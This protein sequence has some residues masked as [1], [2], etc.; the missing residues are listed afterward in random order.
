MGTR[1]F[2]GSRGFLPHLVIRWKHGGDVPAHSR[3][4]FSCSGCETAQQ[5]ET[6]LGAD[7]REFGTTALATEPHFGVCMPEASAE[8]R[9]RNNST[10]RLPGCPLTRIMPGGGWCCLAFVTTVYCVTDTALFCICGSDGGAVPRRPGLLA[11]GGLL[12][13][14]RC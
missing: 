2:A 6:R 7:P 8:Q 1:Y 10:T 4:S 9:A 11:T 5:I 14:G 3:S 13:D 12:V